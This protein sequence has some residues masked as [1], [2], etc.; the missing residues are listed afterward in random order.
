MWI[1][2]VRPSQAKISEF[3]KY[4]ILKWENGHRMS[5]PPPKKYNP[6]IGQP[7]IKIKNALT[8]PKNQKF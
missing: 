3:L 1:L 6:L 7:P 4:C 2:K 5:G 8:S